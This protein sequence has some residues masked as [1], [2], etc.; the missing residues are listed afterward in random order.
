MT[1]SS[2]WFFY[3]FLKGAERP[4]PHLIEV[5]AQTRHAL[6]IE[7]VEPARACLGIGHKAHILQYLEVLRNSRTRD[8]EHPR[9]FVHGD[10]PGGEL[11]KDRHPGWVGEGIKPGLKVSVH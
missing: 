10:G 11:L 5:R 7:L 4:G 2:G 8:R 3:D 1:I 9:E 6:R